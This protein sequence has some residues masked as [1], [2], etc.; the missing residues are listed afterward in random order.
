M[1]NEVDKKIIRTYLTKLFKVSR[2]KHN[3]KF[4]RAIVLP[5]KI[6]FLSENKSH[7]AIKHEILN[8]TKRILNYDITVIQTVLEQILPLSLK[9]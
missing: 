9:D 4:K 7:L 1:I 8:E 5:N 6:Y 3:G 2:I